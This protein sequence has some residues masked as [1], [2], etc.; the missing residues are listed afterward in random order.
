VRVEGAD[1]EMQG[2]LCVIRT[3]PEMYESPDVKVIK[4]VY[5]RPVSKLFRYYYIS[6]NAELS[7]KNS[8]PD[9]SYSCFDYYSNYRSTVGYG[10]N[11]SLK[12]PVSALELTYTSDDI[13]RKVC[14]SVDDMSFEVTLD[15][16]GEIQ[17]RPEAVLDSLKYG[18]MRGGVFDNAVSLERVGEWTAV[19]QGSVEVTSSAFSN[20]LMTAQIDMRKASKI[21][22][23]V[24]AGNGVELLVD[25]ETMMKHLN[26]YRTTDRTETVLLDL[27]KGRHDLIL[28]SYNRFEDSVCAGISFASDQKLYRM[29]IE[30]PEKLEDDQVNVALTA[31]DIASPHSD[32]GLHNLILRLVK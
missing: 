32:C 16:E 17:L 26:P 20:Y 14:V 15:G 19:Q 25:G 12:R 23:D 9:Y 8:L 28:R 30:L 31:A 1:W 4:V 5:D 3:A 24:R 22:L 13:G 11:V 6:D 27:S 18:R 7:W 2:G 10:W 29:R 21:L